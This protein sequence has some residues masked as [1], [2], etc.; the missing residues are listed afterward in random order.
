MQEASNMKEFNVSFSELAI[1]LAADYESIYVID[2][3]DDS[4][5]EY[6]TDGDA[7]T[8]SVASS[9]ADFYADTV[10][11]TRKLLHPDDQ[12]AFL[13]ALRRDSMHNAF[14]HSKSFSINYRLIID[15]TPKYYFLKTI[16]GTGSSSRFIIIGV[17][18]VDD[19]MRR[20]ME[21]EKLTATYSAV[22][23]SLASLY[24]VI[25]YIDTRTDEYIE[26]NSTEKF[27]QLGLFTDGKDFFKH[28]Q[29]DAVELVHPD[30]RARVL[31]ELT[32]ENLITYLQM[33][34]SFSITHRQLLEGEYQYVNLLAFR[35]LG[36]D[37]HIVI[38]VRNIDAQKRRELA[39]AEENETYSRI[40]KSLSSRYEVIYYI[41][42]DTNAYTEYSCSDDYAKLGIRQQGDDFFIGC[43]RDIKEFIH[44]DDQKTLLE[45]L[46]KQTLMRNL[47]DN[48]AL[49]YTY[50]QVLGDRTQYV[51]MLIVQPKNDSHHI[52]MAV[53]NVDAQIRREQL[54]TDRNKTFEEVIKALARRYEVIYYVNLD[55]N[56]YQEFSSSLKYAKLEIGATGQDFF[57]ET[58][59]NIKHD[60]YA[61]DYPLMAECMTKEHLLE[62]MDETGT[63]AINYRL[64]LDGEPQFVTLFAIRPKEDSNHIIIAVANVD[65]AKRREIAYRDALGSAI[66]LASRDAL[67]GVKNKHAYVQ[68]EIELD[69]LIDEDISPDFAIVIHDINGLKH[70]N[71][72]MGHRAGDLYIREAC[73]M[74]CKAFQ[75]S[76]VYRVGGDEF[77]VVLRGHDYENRAEIMADFKEMMREHVRKG[78]VTVAT[79]IS[80]FNRET[81]LR[82]QDVFERADNAMYDDKK[83]FKAASKL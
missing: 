68:T 72:T 45:N 31:R 71:D 32:K 1:A 18:N 59:R 76:P 25:Y 55:T 75:H 26:Y 14:I 67:T 34:Y 20:R 41:N 65:A 21:S 27:A 51:S 43:A 35:Q 50:R 22:A 56:E 19:E 47:R 39:I 49:N 7:Q 10:Q 3:S 64:M 63:T 38:A 78:L 54:Y 24:E 77:A 15:G 36:T 5:V 28:I 53:L 33:H 73:T 40:A 17:R 42:T 16:R 4:Y 57:G 83:R 44:P 8:L 9:G 69:G 62:S 46:D 52:I 23:K 81:D 80:D 30:D 37:D 11:N 29:D 13:S 60:I 82:V 61:E 70:V 6:R 2:T 12:E 58:Q 48:S 74:I 79:G 66:D